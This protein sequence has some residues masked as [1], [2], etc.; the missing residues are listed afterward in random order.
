ME[1]SVTIGIPVYQAANY[2]EAALLSALDQTFAEVEVLVVDDGCT[3][4][5]MAL[6][7]RLCREH[8]RGSHIRVL[9]NEGNR[10]VGQS[11]NRIID[12]AGGRWLYFL[13]SDDVMAANALATLVA[14]AERCQSQVVYG[15][16]ERIW[17]DS[18]VRAG[19]MAYPLRRF[20]EPDQLAV[21]VFADYGAF[22]SSVCNCLYDLAFLR[23]T[24]IRFTDARF[25]EDTTFTYEL[26]TKAVRASL[27]S[28]VTYQYRCHEH[29]L[30]HYQQR[31]HW[32][33]QEVL[34]N[35]ATVDRMKQRCRQLCTKP[36]AGSYCY[37]VEMY[38]F[39]IVAHVLKNRRHIL[40]G[41]TN[42][43]LRSFLRFPL[44]LGRLLCFRQR[45]LSCLLLWQLS[46][47]PAWLIPSVVN[48]IRKAKGL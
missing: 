43:E 38:S 39:Y 42:A 24:G 1:H 45:R 3:D 21:H 44:P 26:V 22:Q 5:S 34:D 19:L 41:V 23:Q 40:P 8:P 47:L 27:L 2:I 33:K 10:G 12:E 11:R 36:Y 9:T 14:E 25:W 18:G 15:S 37:M 35:V 13:D 7:E 48:L 4:G 6:V 17:S 28:T 29:S 46:V 30:S 20:D 32:S 31:E 16:M